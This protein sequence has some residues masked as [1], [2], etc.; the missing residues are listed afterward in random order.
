MANLKSQVA[1]SRAWQQ[2]VEVAHA[3]AVRQQYRQSLL[4]DL[5]AIV[6]PPQSP[7]PTVVVVE[8]EEEESRQWFQR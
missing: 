7:E 6:N 3:N 8:S 2:N 4:D 5:K 1:Q